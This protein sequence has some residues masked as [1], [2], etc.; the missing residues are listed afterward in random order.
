MD[1]WKT[2]RHWRQAEANEASMSASVLIVLTAN[3][4]ESD[5]RR[6]LSR[7]RHGRPSGRSLYRPT[8]I[9]TVALLAAHIAF[10]EI[11]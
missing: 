6:F 1:L 3:A 10:H 5:Q 9:A 7:R 11:P 8:L 2:V 4:S